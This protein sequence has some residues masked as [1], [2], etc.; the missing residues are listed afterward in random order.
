MCLEQSESLTVKSDGHALQYASE[1]LKNDKEVVMEAVKSDWV[2]LEYAPKELKK[3]IA[4]WSAPIFVAEY[5]DC[6]D[7]GWSSVIGTNCAVPYT[8]LV[9]V[10]MN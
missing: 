6:P 7:K 9:E 3:D 5:G 8:S 2:A 10:C 1:E 4:K